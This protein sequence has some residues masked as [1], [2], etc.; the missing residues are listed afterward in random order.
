M[1]QGTDQGKTG[2]PVLSVNDWG[3]CSCIAL[4]RE[5]ESKFEKIVITMNKNKNWS[6]SK[7]AAIIIAIV[8]GIL[9]AYVGLFLIIAYSSNYG[10]YITQCSNLVE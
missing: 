9:I 8:A 2:V 1:Q 5:I 7:K 3:P 4:I 10:M 6:K